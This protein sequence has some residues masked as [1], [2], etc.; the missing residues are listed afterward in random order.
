MA[1]GVTGDPIAPGEPQRRRRQEEPVATLGAQPV[2]QV[3]QIPEFAERQAELEQAVMMQRQHRHG[4]CSAGTGR[5]GY[6]ST[7]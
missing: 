5:A 7:A 3:A 6:R 1:T 2:G 4:P